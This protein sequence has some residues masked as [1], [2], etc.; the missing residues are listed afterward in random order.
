[1]H[2]NGEVLRGSRSLV[3]RVYFI[4]TL[5]LFELKYVIKS[6]L[7]DSQSARISSV[8]ARTLEKTGAG[9]YSRKK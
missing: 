8:Q 4:D 5:L 6:V 2:S 7:I 3:T 9:K 1:L